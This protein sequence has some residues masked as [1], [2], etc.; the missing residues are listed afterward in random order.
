MSA[1]ARCPWRRSWALVR[2]SSFRSRPACA[3]STPWALPAQSWA[4][5]LLQ[6]CPAS[7][8]GLRRQSRRCNLCA[9]V[10]RCNGTDGGQRALG[11]D[12]SCGAVTY[13][14]RAIDEQQRLTWL[15]ECM[16]ESLVLEEIRRKIRPPGIKPAFLRRL[17]PYVTKEERESINQKIESATRI[18]EKML[19]SPLF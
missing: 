10:G 4:V 13:I 9:T 3:L 17:G 8:P 14:S 7:S 15:K 19:L 1:S 12:A 5:Q 6:D 18:F 11:D 16:A 2:N